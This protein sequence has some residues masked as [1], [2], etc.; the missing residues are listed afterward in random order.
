MDVEKF[1]ETLAKI[2][3]DKNGVDIKVDIGLKGGD[4][5]GKKNSKN[6][7]QSNYKGV[8]WSEGN[9]T[10]KRYKNAQ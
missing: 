7:K 10:Y 9:K 4:E 1:F 5:I 8:R 6:Y 3:G 2:V